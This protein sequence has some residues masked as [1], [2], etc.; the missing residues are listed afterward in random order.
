MR[1]ILLALLAWMAAWAIPVSAQT[2]FAPG[3][4]CHAAA[5][6]GEDYA[7]LAQDPA[8]WSCKG[9]ALDPEAT[10]HL[11]RYDLRGESSGATPARYISTEYPLLADLEMLALGANGE[12]SSATVAPVNVHVERGAWHAFL[13]I[14]SLKSPLQATILIIENVRYPDMFATAKAVA[15]LPPPAAAGRNELYAALL[16]GLLLAP[17][18][19]DLGFARA[20]REKFPLFHALFCFLACVQTASISSLL[21]QFFDIDYKLE[22][23]I[24]YMS[25]DLM[26]AAT[27]LFFRSF[28]EPEAL[29]R[30]HRRLLVGLTGLCVVVSLLTTFA[31]EAL[32]EWNTFVFYG[33]YLLVLAG[34]FFCY[35]TAFRRRSR[36][37]RYVALSFAP[38]LT[39]GVIRVTGGLVPALYV[40]FDDMWAQS[41]ALF[42]EVLVTAFAVTNRFLHLKRERDMAVHEVRN[43]EELSEHDPMTGLLNRRAI[44]SR[45]PMLR[46]SGFTALA[47]LDLDRF[48]S[49]NDRYG[50]AVGDEVLCAAAAALAH[51]DDDDLLAFRLGGEEFML[52]LRGSDALERAEARRIAISKH[53]AKVAALQEPATASMGFVDAASGAL[54]SVDFENVYQRADKLLYDAKEAGR[55]RTISERLKLFKP[56]SPDRR[57]A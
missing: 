57:A 35:F 53:T 15:Q 36:A 17:L 12:T 19:F 26:L 38:L 41:L 20:L 46:A 33:G 50:H 4:L 11:F 42:F 9:E 54:A 45:Y 14:P 39:I 23:I 56:R 5:L 27:L 51:E 18:F 24:G 37:V 28:I 22:R 1:A 55:N 47:I 10:R 7:A 6:P 2:G 44:E 8:R 52:I 30:W 29:D 34:L 32:G 43:L 49:I 48:K 31:T 13:P 40:E 3:S 25:F 16:C 21:P